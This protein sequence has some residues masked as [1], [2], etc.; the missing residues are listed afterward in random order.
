[1]Q[2]PKNA[3]TTTLAL[4]KVRSDFH[5]RFEDSNVNWIS[6]FPMRTYYPSTL[7]QLQPVAWKTLAWSVHHPPRSSFIFWLCA[8]QALSTSDKVIKWQPQVDQSYNF[9]KL[10]FETHSYLFFECTW[11]A[12]I[13][14]KCFKS[15]K[16]HRPHF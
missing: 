10:H 7:A 16:L 1:M 8:H 13:L 3:S 12:T 14:L 15:V 9:C 2:K 6:T 11:T 4:F 5:G